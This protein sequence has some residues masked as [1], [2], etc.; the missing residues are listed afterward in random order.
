MPELLRFP[1]EGINITFCLSSVS[2]YC[3]RPGCTNALPP[4]CHAIWNGKGDAQHCQSPSLGRRRRCFCQGGLLQTPAQTHLSTQDLQASLI[5]AYQSL[6]AHQTLPV[7]INTCLCTKPCLQT[8]LCPC[9]PIPACTPCLVHQTAC[10]ANPAS[11]PSSTCTPTLPAQPVFACAPNP[12]HTPYLHT[13]RCLHSQRSRRCPCTCR[14]LPLALPCL[15]HPLTPGIA[16]DTITRHRL[17]APGQ[18]ITP[19][20]P[21]GRG[22]P[23]HTPALSRPRWQPRPTCSDR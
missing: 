12:V 16:P 10:T 23:R 11:T 8:K 9:T 1:S 20:P 14:Q 4:A 6:S 5:P 13:K 3:A 2:P 15:L 7:H 18:P 17:P 21:H 22:S 19:E